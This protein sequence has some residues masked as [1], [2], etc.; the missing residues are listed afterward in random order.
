MEEKTILINQL[1]V[2]YRI[3]G[4][5]PVV[6]ILHGWGGSSDSWANVQNALAQK[7]YKVVCPDFPG[8]RKSANPKRPW[9]VSDYTEWAY[10]FADSQNFKKFFL[11]GHSFGGRV[12]IKFAAI[13]P[14][15]L[16]NLILCA[17]G[18]IKQK[19]GIKTRI[20]I[21]LA[22]HGKKI[23]NNKL[24]TRFKGMAEG[25]F[26]TFLRRYDYIRAQGIMRPTIK[27][28]LAEDLLPV[29]QKI[30]TKTLIIWGK[31]DKIL[32]LENAYVFKS[33]I[34]NSELKVLP[35]TGHSPHLKNSEELIS[36]I[37]SFLKI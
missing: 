22:K 21:K 28:V 6:L 7:G 20:I 37:I 31:N 16:N 15:R 3:A 2:S 13:Y 10:S 25:L 9:G 17:S 35:Q 23:F 4:Q 14:E 18:G 8:F 30:K 32:P 29:A 5:G 27:K 34:R 33:N 24:L 36:I 11:L 12:S 26:Y 1:K 19:K